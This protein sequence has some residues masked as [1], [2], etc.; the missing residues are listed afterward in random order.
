MHLRN[1]CRG[2]GL[3]VKA[4]KHLFGLAAQIFAQL[5]A[6]KL[7]GHGRHLAVELFKL[8]DPVGAEQVGTARQ[9]LPELHECGPQLLQRQ[10]H[11]HGRLDAGQ[12][13]GQVPVQGL[14]CALQLVGQAQAAHG[15]AKP[16]AHHHAQN[17]FQAAQIARGSQGLDQHG[18]MIVRRLH[19]GAAGQ[20]HCIGGKCVCG[21][22]FMSSGSRPPRA[23][24]TSHRP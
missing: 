24:P 12:V 11:L 18:A 17:F 5:G 10:P 3:G 13:T 21:P 6:Q 20:C 19:A 4:C 1:R 9:Q 15:V 22:A 16:M 8:G 14:A 2:Q 23:G 7:Q